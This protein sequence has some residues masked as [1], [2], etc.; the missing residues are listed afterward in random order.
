MKNGNCFVTNGPFINLTF[1]DNGSIH[2][3]GSI[4]SSNFGS[5]KVSISSTSEFGLIKDI[6]LMKGIIKEQKE[7]VFFRILNYGGYE[8]EKYI[9][10]NIENECYFRCIVELESISSKNIFAL[11]NP[12]WLKPKMN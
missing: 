2:E 8:L 4:I 1:E 10:I 7:N 9:E 3:M 11:T 5:F 12:I 6:T